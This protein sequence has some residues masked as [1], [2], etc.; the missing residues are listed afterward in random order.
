MLVSRLFIMEILQKQKFYNPHLYNR[1]V[2]FAGI[3]KF[4]FLVQQ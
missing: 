3:I 4:L 2:G 1:D